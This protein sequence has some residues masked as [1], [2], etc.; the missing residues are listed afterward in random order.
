M[1]NFGKTI[2]LVFVSFICLVNSMTLATGKDTIPQI[3]IDWYTALQNGDEKMLEAILDDA[4]TIE[5]KDLGIIQ[6]KAE[7]TEAL[8]EWVELNDDA[9]LLTRLNSITG[10]EIKLDVCYK[11]KTNELQTVEKFTVINDLIMKSGQ[12]QVSQSCSGF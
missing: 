5:L 12:E 1:K 11:F 10:N 3:V 6:T 9:K 4:A 7:F 2:P 8:D